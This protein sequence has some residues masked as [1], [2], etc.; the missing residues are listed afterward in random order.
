MKIL[1][2]I[3]IN[4]NDC[5][6][7]E[8][9]IESVL[10]QSNR[11]FEYLVID[12]GSTDGSKELIEKYASQLTYWVSEKDGGIYHAMNKGIE[13]AEAEYCLFLNSGDFLFNKNVLSDVIPFLGQPAIVYGDMMIDWGS[14]HI[15][16]GKMPD[17]ITIDHMYNDT[18][19]HPVSFIKK[20]LFD[21]FGKYDETYKMVADYEF[22]FRTIIS[23]KVSVK[24]IPVTISVYN[25]KGISSKAENKQRELTERQRV[26]NTYLKP[27]ELDALR[28]RNKKIPI[29][30]F[31]KRKLKFN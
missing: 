5:K 30:E 19:W 14:N 8:K 22:F 21:T 4:Y 15:T 13:R 3:T 28:K 10:A 16:L 7:L 6:G 25:V 18:L 12:G 11:N 26:L 2:I 23:H 29:L 9:T 1:S 24:H 27:A 31:I 17:E 20:E